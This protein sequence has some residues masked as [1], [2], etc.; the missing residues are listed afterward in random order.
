MQEKND[1]KI[2]EMIKSTILFV[3]FNLFCNS[4]FSQNIKS[5]PTNYR[6]M[7][8]ESNDLVHTERYTICNNHSERLLILFSEDVVCNSNHINM[9]KR[10]LLRR[11]GDFSLSMLI[12]D[13]VLIKD[14]IPIVPEFFVKSLAKGETFDVIIKGKDTDDFSLNEFEKH[15]LICR[16]T[17]FLTSQIGMPNF[18]ATLKELHMLYPYSYIVFNSCELVNFVDRFKKNKP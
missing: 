18:V 2:K 17:D 9:L 15:I 10:K 4:I 5:Y 16:E 13:N 11:Y 12:W 14:T 7:N 8:N 1:K 6:I 3:L